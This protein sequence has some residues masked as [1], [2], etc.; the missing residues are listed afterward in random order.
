[1]P[2]RFK[3]QAERKGRVEGVGNEPAALAE[4]GLVVGLVTPSFLVSPA[5]F[6]FAQRGRGGHTPKGAVVSHSRS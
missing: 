4:A 6:A 2:F 5:F 3:H 1:M